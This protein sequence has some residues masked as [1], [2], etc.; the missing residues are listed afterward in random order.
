VK[1]IGGGIIGSGTEQNNRKKTDWK[2]GSAYLYK[3]NGG[4]AIGWVND[5]QESDAKLN[6]S[7]TSMDVV[8][9]AIKATEASIKSESEENASSS[10]SK[11]S[12]WAAA[13]VELFQKKLNTSVEELKLDSG[14]TAVLQKIIDDIAKEEE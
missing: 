6:I 2:Q 8:I 3:S 12:R 10:P 11:P 13:V 9:Y 1:S 7:D 4:K 5:K 14:D